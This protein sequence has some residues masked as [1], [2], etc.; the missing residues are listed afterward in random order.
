MKIEIKWR[1]K[2]SSWYG[3]GGKTNVMA[4]GESSAYAM[5]G[6]G[7]R[8]CMVKKG[9]KMRE[10]IRVKLDP[11]KIAVAAYCLLTIL[12]Y[13]VT[14]LLRI[15][16]HIPS[17]PFSL[18]VYGMLAYKIAMGRY[19]KK[20]WAIGGVVL[21]MSL[22]SL[23]HLR[24]TTVLTNVLVLL[25]LKEMDIDK[26]LKPLF[27]CALASYVAVVIFSLVG[28]GLPVSMTLDFR[29]TG[30]MTR[31]C[32]G[33]SH[34][35]ILH[36]FS[37]RLMCL[38]AGAYF[39]KLNWGQICG[40]AIFNYGI[41]CLTDSRTGVMCGF[42]LVVLLTI[43]RYVPSLVELKVWKAGVFA[44]AFIIVVVG[45]FMVTFFEKVEFLS[46]VNNLFT[47]R[48]RLSNEAYQDIGISWWGNVSVE[49]YTIDNSIM[50][51]LLQY[52]II[53]F[54]IYWIGIF[55]M[56]WHALK[57][58]KYYVIVLI[59]VFGVYALMEGSVLLKIFRN[60]PMLYLGG[61]IFRSEYSQKM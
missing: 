16:F 39:H 51:M 14:D 5:A 30:E 6:P 8:G 54:A 49:N 44:G 24:D 23:Y 13:G 11:A 57:K 53:P 41:Y 50:Y 15:G 26:I 55:S 7:I 33:Y 28:V 38:Y 60:I 48:L 20:E 42:I 46:I 43:Y 25:S 27:W 36:L 12:Y 37:V 19:E 52:G 61:E 21:L 31:Y 32:F 1:K 34:P 40:L 59:L 3:W 35:N 58:R 18:L 56:L 2:G 10:K 22:I 45:I 17:A 47:G 9:D 29:G 4:T